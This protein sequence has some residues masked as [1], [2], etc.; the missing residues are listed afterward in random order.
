MIVMNI[1]RISD[2]SI[3][4]HVMRNEKVIEKVISE[5]ELFFQEKYASGYHDMLLVLS[6]VLL[7]A[8][9][10]INSSKNSS[11]I[12]CNI[13]MI[14]PGSYR[15]DTACNGDPLESSLLADGG[16]N[17]QPFYLKSYSYKLIHAIADKVEL[18]SKENR[19]V[20]Y[21]GIKPPIFSLV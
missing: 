8:I 2:N 3:T 6:E 1:K 20:V 4:F 9:T 17:K 16:S 12:T 11:N 18:S 10:G 13:E 19:I 14:D 5:T 15:I 7:N 21:M